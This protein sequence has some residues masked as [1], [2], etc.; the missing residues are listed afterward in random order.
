MKKYNW[1][2]IQADYDLGMSQSDL[3]KKYGMSSRSIYIAIQRGDFKSRAISEAVK[4]S[5]ANN[6]RSTDFNKKMGI[7]VSKTVQLKVRNGT[8]HTSLAKSMHIEYNGVDLHGSWELAFAKYLDINHI[9]WVR[10]KKAF[11]YVFEGKNR[12]YTPDFYLID[13]DEY[14][15]IKGYKTAKDIAKWNQ[16]PKHSKLKVLMQRDLEKLCII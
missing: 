6:P 15:E 2:Q 16:F 3:R 1:N 14:I 12:K 7:S 13:T 11:D 5:R 9:K 10:N 8:W 4:I